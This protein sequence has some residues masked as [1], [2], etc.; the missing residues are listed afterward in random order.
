MFKWYFGYFELNKNTI[1]INST[2]LN[3]WLLEDLKL[4]M[5]CIIFLLS[6]AGYE[7]FLIYNNMVYIIYIYE[8]I[9]SGI[10]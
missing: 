4:Y 5:A 2:F 8:Y 3:M 6:C 1:K 9:V 10:S 7:N